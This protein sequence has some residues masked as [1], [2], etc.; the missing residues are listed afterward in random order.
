MSMAARCWWARPSDSFRWVLAASL[1][2]LFFG[3]AVPTM[4]ATDAAV[5]ANQE[6]ARQVLAATIQ[7]LGGR[8]WLDLHTQR[9][10]GKTAA[11]FQGNPTGALAETT[12]TTVLPYKQR[13]DFAP[14]G[15]VVQIYVAHRGWEITYKGKKDIAPQQMETYLRWRDHSLGVALRRWFADPSTVLI[16]DGQTLIERRL[17]DKVTL[18]NRNNEAITLEVDIQTHLPVRLSFEWRDPKFHDK[19]LDVVE[20]DNYQI[21]DGIA[22]PYTT[23]RMHNGETVRQRY[24]TRMEYN[25]AVRKDLFN[26]DLVAEHLH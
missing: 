15:R 25:V 24:V 2:G 14:K 3:P 16:D 18:I 11:F 1:V 7:A 8:A 13:I 5:S 12:E 17:V 4:R 22:T 20:Y 26:P 10:K 19:N 23:T 21:V 9:S 6:K